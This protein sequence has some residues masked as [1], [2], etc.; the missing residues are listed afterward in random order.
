[1]THFTFWFTFNIVSDG[2]PIPVAMRS[3]SY[4]CGHSI[5]GI[6]GSNPAEG[7]GFRI[8]GLLCVV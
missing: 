1:M 4:V 2:W 6:T 5:A 8:L 7:M 3:E